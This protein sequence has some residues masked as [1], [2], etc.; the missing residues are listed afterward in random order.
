MYVVSE[1]VKIFADE[2]AADT[3]LGPI[4]QQLLTTACAGLTSIKVTAS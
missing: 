4:L 1:L 3:V 2:P